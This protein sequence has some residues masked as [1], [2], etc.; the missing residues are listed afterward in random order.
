MNDH[1]TDTVDGA[2]APDA[3]TDVVDAAPED[4][5]GGRF[6]DITDGDHVRDL[7]G[8]VA[9]VVA[10]QLPWSLSAGTAD[11]PWALAGVLLALV[12]L[13]LPYLARLGALPAGWT[14]RTTRRAR[15]LLVLPLVAAAVAQVVLDAVA[16][17]GHRGV[18]AGVA[19]GLAAAALAATPRTCELGPVPLDD[20]GRAWTRVS[21]V[22]G[23]LAALAPLAWLVVLVVARLGVDER[24]RERD[25]LTTPLVLL[26]VATVLVLAA[27]V[28]PAVLAGLTRRAAWRRAAV[29]V[30][31]TGAVALFVTNGSGDVR[32]RVESVRTLAASELGV[33]AVV[34]LGYGLVL[35]PAVAA[36]VTSPAVVRA[37]R[38]EGDPAIGWFVTARALLALQA[39]LALVLAVATV[40]A[41][42]QEGG[43]ATSALVPGAVVA[44]VVG[45]VALRVRGSLVGRPADARRTALATTVGLLV[46]GIVLV[47]VSELTAA[48]L[49]VPS[50]AATL[51]ALVAGVG[52][53]V[54]VLVSLT[55]PRPVR[56]HL[57]A[58]P[59]TPRPDAGRAVREW[60]PRQV[61]AAVAPS[62]STPSGVARAGAPAPSVPATAAYGAVPSAAPVGAAYGAPDAA[63]PGAV[64]DGATY[65]TTAAPEPT[66]PVTADPLAPSLVAPDP[67]APGAAAPNPVAQA[68]G[69]LAGPSAPA[70]AVQEPGQVSPVTD[71]ASTA[72]AAAEPVVLP[73]PGT[74][75]AV[76]AE[77]AGMHEVQPGYLGATDNETQVIPTGLVTQD[78]E[79]VELPDE[80]EQTI[81]AS[82]VAERRPASAAPTSPAA[83]GA[84]DR[85]QRAEAGF[86]WAQAVDGATPG[87]TLAQIAQDAPSLR[88]AIALNPTTYPALLDWLAQLGDAEVDDALRSRSR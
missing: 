52:L 53:P 75:G 26:T 84:E 36:L 85:T 51:L 68:P 50:G 14:V 7:L 77:Q 65:G 23:V 67:V 55:L 81:L 66:V 27:L 82:E 28:V 73:A 38:D 10:L 59:A 37:A 12:P 83:A 31:T 44:L 4:V 21:T 42:V 71:V 49:V 88:P 19:L 63:A 8:L 61:P 29:T 80:I 64:A 24:V 86:T 2:P 62:T 3:P 25:E 40:L 11:V 54:A 78:G 15:V 17:D 22:V 34:L 60:Q 70:G 79:P 72:P 30:A 20:A 58:N 45:G 69:F 74:S 56:E 33:S 32:G 47:V 57:E 48:S 9:A 16:V 13:A 87:A 18:G 41:V 35:V 1:G 6:D 76:L 46:L 43:P 5:A 39:V